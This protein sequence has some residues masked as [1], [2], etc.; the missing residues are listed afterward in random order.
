MCVILSTFLNFQTNHIF[1]LQNMSG[2]FPF[3]SWEKKSSKIIIRARKGFKGCKWEQEI[4][5][6]SF[7]QSHVKHS[8]QRG[9]GEQPSCCMY[10]ISGRGLNAAST[11]GFTVAPAKVNLTGALRWSSRRQCSRQRES[12]EGQIYEWIQTPKCLD[13][14][15]WRCFKLCLG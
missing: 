6:L 11:P 12:W 14:H 4:T 8:R 5:I 1:R 2:W 15:L 7:K 3:G 13:W 9:K 10:W